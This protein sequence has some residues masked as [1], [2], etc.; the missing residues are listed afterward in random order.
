MVYVPFIC[1]LGNF[2]LSFIELL[3]FFNVCD[4]DV[5]GLFTSGSGADS[6]FSLFHKR[7]VW[8]FELLGSLQ[9]GHFF[10]DIIG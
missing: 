7:L 5:L 4:P 6:Y 1:E 10:L 3:N 2:L 9:R 8:Q